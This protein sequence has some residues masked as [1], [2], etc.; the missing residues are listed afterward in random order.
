MLKDFR[1]KLSGKLGLSAVLFGCG[2]FV[3]LT[4]LSHLFLYVLWSS[5]KAGHPV[6]YLLPPIIILQL[7]GW[8]IDGYV[9]MNIWMRSPWPRFDFGWLIVSFYSSVFWSIVVY[10]LMRFEKWWEAQKK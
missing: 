2:L 10:G 3:G 7:P 9:Q 6:G 4:I 5:I 8:L 1:K